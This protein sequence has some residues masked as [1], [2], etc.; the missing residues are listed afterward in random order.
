[1]AELFEKREKVAVRPPS[2]VK[3]KK[4]WAQ[5]CFFSRSNKRKR[6]GADYVKA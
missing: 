2:S 3:Q 1:M 4:S 6:N 5:I